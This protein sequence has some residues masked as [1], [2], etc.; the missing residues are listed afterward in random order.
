[1]SEPQ[2]LEPVLQKFLDNRQSLSD[3]EFAQ[4]L[5][6]L[7]TQPAL[8]EL[9]KD[10]LLID[11]LL[12]QQFQ[13]ERKDFI[14]KFE[15]R[16]REENGHGLISPD[17][18]APIETYA[19]RWPE[20]AETNGGLVH[21]PANGS[22]GPT[23][24][25]PLTKRHPSEATETLTTTAT[26]STGRP[27]WT[28]AISFLGLLLVAGGFLGLEYTEAAR[29]I[30]RIEGVTGM[31]F[32]YRGDVGTV[33]AN[34][35][36]VLPGDEIR[37]RE[38]A[39]VS[40]KFRDQSRMTLAA[41]SRAVFL[42]RK[43]RWPGIAANE[44]A[45]EVRVL[46]GRMESWIEPQPANRPMR[47]LAPHFEAK[48]LGT[49]LIVTVDEAQSRLEVL[50]GQVEVESKHPGEP[51]LEIAAGHQLIATIGEL[52]ASPGDWPINPTGLAFLLSPLATVSRTA[53]QGVQLLAEGPNQSPGVLRPRADAQFEQGKM[54]FRGGAFLVDDSTTSELLKA[55]QETNEISVE[56]TFQTTNHL[57]TG[58]ARW[59]SFSSDS[60]VGNMAFEQVGHRCM[61]RLLTT[62]DDGA[63]I[64]HN[65][66]LFEIPDDQPH[67]VV[68]TYSPGEV[69][70]YLD[71]QQVEITTSIEGTFAAWQPQHL[72][73]G[74]EWTG[75]RDWQ[76]QLTGV[77]LYARA[78]PAEEAAR[79]ALHFRL[80]FPLDSV[81]SEQGDK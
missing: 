13:M 3:E 70:C 33:A 67:H 64:Y 47:I 42:P 5:E 68:L 15:V 38:D 61:L 23:G 75:G 58:P 21:S 79:N 71:G 60:E 30:G 73:F 74:D 6:T 51:S 9:L 40:F 29:K 65:V 4:F 72:L 32:I 7:R 10:H 54:D 81:D 48:V 43:D 57:P 63:A 28:L 17:P 31:A 53:N 52:R 37:V 20:H 19:L 25:L 44:V 80:Q 18:T 78:I 66:P 26:L 41:N 2:A 50:A 8:A 77:A 11:E 45:K 69:H 39:T 27:G 22:T 49:R 62:N 12:A 55:F 46:A 76:G 1:M 56:F 36:A 59:L 14:G 24:A 34:G 16:L 35:M